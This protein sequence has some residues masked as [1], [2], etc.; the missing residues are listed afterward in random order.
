M[1]IVPAG[2]GLGLAPPEDSTAAKK[3]VAMSHQSEAG[4]PDPVFQ[5]GVGG[6]GVAQDPSGCR[7]G[8]ECQL[9]A[10]ELGKEFKK[11]K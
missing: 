3:S 11:G 2:N 10:P 4:V 8:V 6:R 5:F 1:D 9:R 7:S